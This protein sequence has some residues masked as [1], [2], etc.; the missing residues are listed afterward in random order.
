VQSGNGG[1]I[2]PPQT[3]AFNIPEAAF[4]KLVFGFENAGDLRS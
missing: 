4:A 3:L 2:K 1:N